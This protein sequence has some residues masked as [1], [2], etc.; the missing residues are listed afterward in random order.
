MN[1]DISNSKRVY[2]VGIKG[3]A[4][5]SLAV[6]CKERGMDVL[7]SDLPESYP[8]DEVLTN[9]KIQ[10]TPG[11]YK[12]NIHDFKPDLVIYTGAHNGGLNEE[13]LESKKIGI[14]ALPHGIAL[15]RFMNGKK[16]ISVS[17][18]HG[19]TTTTAMIA[20]LLKQAGMD[21]SFV[22]GSGIIQGLGLPGH[23]GLGEYFI[24]EA[25]EYATDPQFDKTPRF[26]WQNPTIL[27]ITNIDFDHPDM[28][29]TLAEVRKAFLDFS[30]K[31]DEKG[32]LFINSE[33]KESHI[34]EENSR[35]VISIG[36]NTTANYQFSKV[37]IGETN[38]TFKLNHNNDSVQIKLLVPGLHNVQNSCLAIAVARELNIN[39][40]TIQTGLSNFGGVKRR[41]EIIA[42]SK[43]IVFI[44]DY[45]HHPREIQS[46][47]AAAKRKYP[48]KR[49][50]AIFQPH[51]YSRTEAFLTDFA[52][53]FDDADIT[54]FTEIYGSSREKDTLGVSG[55]QL[56]ALASQKKHNTYYAESNNE[57]VN[58]L[59]RNLKQNDVVI[60]MGAGNIFTWEHEVIEKSIN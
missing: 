53:S 34:F 46:T 24:A 37:S 15:G 57:T 12:K 55:K 11:F 7:G 10:T 30:H 19:K 17:G 5:S 13:V 29:S 52:H 49:I 45:A 43:G 35:H 60:F 3:I 44:D 4:M 28:Y 38:T 18:C 50:I 8:S 16:Q 1:F 54:I 39:W 56:A 33:D 42:N 41:F 47:L 26:M 48:S 51:T 25:D 6:Y 22:I 36:S 32:M 40:K 2:F 31:L 9:A 14:P 20:T 21:P 27:V 59:R 23:Y 58:V